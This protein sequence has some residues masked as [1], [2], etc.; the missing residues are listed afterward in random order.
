MTLEHGPS[1]M[2]HD[3]SICSQG[4]FRSTVAPAEGEVVGA[5]GLEPWTR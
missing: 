1:P 3:M 2:R 4:T 5:H